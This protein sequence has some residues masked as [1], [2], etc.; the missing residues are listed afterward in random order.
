MKNYLNDHR[1]GKDLKRIFSNTL[2]FIKS[3]DEIS[4]LIIFIGMMLFASIGIPAFRTLYNV[5]VVIRQFSL[6]TIVAMG[7]AIVLITGMFD[8]SVGAIVALSGITGSYLVVMRDW[9]VWLSVLG[10]ITVGCCCGLF[11]GFLVSKVKINPIIATVA[12]GW[13]FSGIIL[14]TTEGWPISNFPSNFAFLGQ[15]SFLGI[16]LPIL[17]MITIAIIITFFLSRTIYGRFLYA[18][19]GNE[20][21]CVFAGVNVGKY[22]IMAYAICGTLSGLAGVILASRMG[23]A[24][25]ESGLSWTLPTVAACVIGG[26]SLQGG[27]GKIYGVVIGA[28]LLGTINNILVLIRVSP[29]WQSLISGL[30]LLFA[31]AYDSFRKGKNLI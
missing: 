27:K 6:V 2:N 25:A 19:G 21:G 31:V 8:L 24:Q 1:K 28:A 5:K 14:V 30:I 3:N 7:Q 20:K 13:I 16:P 4:I 26:V 15:G 10:A 23:S 22:K 29:Y 18:V 17:M 9:P 12:S 11:N